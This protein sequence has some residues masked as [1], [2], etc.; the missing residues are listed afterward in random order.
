M[1]MPICLDGKYQPVILRNNVVIYT[2]C[3][4]LRAYSGPCF[5]FK[6]ISKPIGPPWPLITCQTMAPSV[7]NNA[8]HAPQ[9]NT[10][11][12]RWMVSWCTIFSRG[13]IKKRAPQLQWGHVSNSITKPPKWNDSS[14]PSHKTWP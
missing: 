14:F 4:A 10:M 12:E 5:L 6:S 11:H 1:T 9:E 3:G 13:H 2:L 7:R 8:W